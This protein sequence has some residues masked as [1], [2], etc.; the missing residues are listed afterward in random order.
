MTS[1]NRPDSTGKRVLSGNS[2]ATFNVLSQ[3]GFQPMTRT[4]YCQ[5]ERLLFPITVLD[6]STA[7]CTQPWQG[8]ESH[9]W[10]LN[11]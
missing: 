8:L 3:A 6:Y 7:I 11:P 1:V 5:V 10:D 9:P 2:R 4:L